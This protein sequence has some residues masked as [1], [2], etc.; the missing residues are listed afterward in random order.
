L[1]TTVTDE[2]TYNINV[3]EIFVRKGPLK[4]VKLHFIFYASLHFCPLSRGKY[5]LWRT[6]QDIAVRAEPIIHHCTLGRLPVC[7]L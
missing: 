3:G 4:A 1:V 5:F 6:V 7:P 2:E